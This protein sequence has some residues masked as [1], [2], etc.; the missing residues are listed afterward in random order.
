MPEFQVIKRQDV[1]NAW[2]IGKRLP[3]GPKVRLHRSGTLFFS[4]V[5]VAA[6]GEEDCRVMVEFDEVAHTLKFTVAEK[7]PRGVTEEDC[8]PMRIRKGPHNRRP[9]GMMSLRALF[10]F[11][12]FEVG[13]PR[14]LE[15]AAIDATSRSITL[16]LPVLKKN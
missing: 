14:D 5:A 2:Q 16:K 1:P 4:V 11:I 3:E 12:G 13:T 10:N 8:F 9:I 7:L 15:I 6:L